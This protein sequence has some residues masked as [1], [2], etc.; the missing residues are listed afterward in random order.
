MY[1]LQTPIKLIRT[2]KHKTGGNY[3]QKENPFSNYKCEAVFKY[4]I[5]TCIFP[6]LRTYSIQIFVGHYPVKNLI[7][8]FQKISQINA[9]F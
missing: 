2:Q 7:L 4:N 5:R 6:L 9:L 8:A 3:D 1:F